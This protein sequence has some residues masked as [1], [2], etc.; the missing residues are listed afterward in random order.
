MYELCS[1]ATNAVVALHRTRQRDRRIFKVIE[2]TFNFE[3][4]TMQSRRVQRFQRSHY[5]YSVGVHHPN[6]HRLSRPL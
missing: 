1:Y 6:H 5:C 2:S 3:D 4:Q